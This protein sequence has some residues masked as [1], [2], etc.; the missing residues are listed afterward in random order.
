MLV[1]DKQVAN[2]SILHKYCIMHSRIDLHDD[3][4]FGGDTDIRY[5][6]PTRIFEKGTRVHT[7]LVH[8]RL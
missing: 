3:F 2:D 6:N 7:I 4:T 5:Q 1:F 8:A